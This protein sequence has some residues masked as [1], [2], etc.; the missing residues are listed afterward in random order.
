[1]YR[2][3][4]LA[5]PPH[6]KAC[7]EQPRWPPQLAGP[8]ID[9]HEREEPEHVREVVDQKQPLWL[10]HENES[11]IEKHENAEPTHASSWITAQP[12]WP[13]HWKSNS[14]DEHDDAAPTQAMV[15]ASG[16]PPV[17]RASALDVPASPDA[18]RASEPDVGVRA[19][20]WGSSPSAG[21]APRARSSRAWS[22]R[23]S[24]LRI[25]DVDTGAPYRPRPAPAASC[26]AAIRG[27]PVDAQS[28]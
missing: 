28:R 9:E 18:A 14:N 11:N 7:H 15:G 25:M 24:R 3:Q 20:G 10:A 21:H 19:S 16:V 26:R 23:R 4:G 17:V 12:S 6:T 22:E 13:R 27:S 1:V 8:G 2:S 5:T